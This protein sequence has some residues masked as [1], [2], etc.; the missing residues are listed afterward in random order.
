MAAMAEP[1]AD[2]VVIGSGA[3]GVAAALAARAE[4]ASVVMLAGR[5]GATA[6]SSATLDLVAGDLDEPLGDA[7]ARLL[8]AEPR[9]AWSRLADEADSAPRARASSIVARAREAF[10]A[11][12]P[13]LADVDLPHVVS[14][15]EPLALPAPGGVLRAV[16]GAPATAARACARAVVAAGATLVVAPLAGIAW[17]ELGAPTTAAAYRAFGARASAASPV[18]LPDEIEPGAPTGPFA[19]AVGFDAADE[20]TLARWA[21]TTL[22]P[23][24][25]DAR[26]DRAEDGHD[27]RGATVVLL[28][29]ALGLSRHDAV[30]AALD[31]GLAAAVPNARVAE[32]TALPPSVPGLRAHRALL[33]AVSAAGVEVRA[34]RATSLQLH[35]DA[36]IARSVPIAPEADPGAAE[37]V[38]AGA[39]VLATGRFLGG[40]LEGAGTP[41]VSAREPVAGLT[42]VDGSGVPV[43]P[44]AVLAA[45]DGVDGGGPA[46]HPLLEGLGVAVDPTGRALDEDGRAASARLFAAGSIVSAHDYA[47]DGAGVGFALVSG[48]LAG[49]HASRLTGRRPDRQASGLARERTAP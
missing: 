27:G 9:H 37:P 7:L 33:R 38:V 6:L 14:T 31:R 26:A 2:V 42:L 19:I 29:P 30:V 34:A 12:L 48:W 11:L 8:R 24:V 44:D 3:A 13:R 10:D 45:H 21:E 49:R 43:G 25:R 41:A 15:D 18:A 40:G 23:A 35:D 17:P 39:A 20:A 4:G 22:G 5:P 1:T 46:R 36:A 28:P 47:R 16:A 32:A